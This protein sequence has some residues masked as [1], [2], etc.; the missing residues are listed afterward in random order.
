MVDF[1]YLWFVV[2]VGILVLGLMCLGVRCW[3]IALGLCLWI[4]DFRLECRVVYVFG[5]FWLDLI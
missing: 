4:F 3:L 5:W 1:I 2:V